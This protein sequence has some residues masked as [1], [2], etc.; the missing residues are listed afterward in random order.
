MGKKLKK[1]KVLQTLVNILY[2]AFIIFIC[3][4]SKNI[5]ND[6]YELDTVPFLIHYGLFLLIYTVAVLLIDFTSVIWHEYGHYVFGKR[7][8]LDFRS[9]NV[10]GYTLKRENGKLKF[11]KDGAIPGIK[12][13][14]NMVADENKRYDKNKIVLHYLAGIIFNVILAIILFIV[15]I[16]VSNGT[17]KLLLL[18]GVVQNLYLA[19]YNA[20]PAVLPTGTNTDALQIMYYLEDSNYIY[21]IARVQKLQEL[22]LSGVELKDVDPSL[23]NKAHE[24]KTNTDVLS[25]MIYVDYLVD[26]GEF[27]EA[28]QYA[29]TIMSDA[30]DYLTEHDVIT[31]KLQL[32][33]AVFYSGEDL[34]IL[35][36]YMDKNVKKL[37][38]VLGEVIPVYISINYMYSALVDKNMVDADKYLSQFEKL[39]KSD[40]EESQI[41]DA[42]E[43]I[44][45]V[46]KRM[47][48][49]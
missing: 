5:N 27:G 16:L 38:D 22:L 3:L 7:A 30:K 47:I 42:E 45:D 24:F 26:K 17:L 2:F 29:K 46:K 11:S 35:K 33:N 43:L 39:K 34:S 23:L 48:S 31:L 44:N 41:K 37:L 18:L 25:G 36:E 14:C 4:Y 6:L 12:G 49:E 9:F 32:M 28:T 19:L 40:F 13:Y 10:L 15:F 8:G 20:V 21:I 1:Y